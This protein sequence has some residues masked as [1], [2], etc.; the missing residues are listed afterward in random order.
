MNFTIQHA[1]MNYS[2]EEG[3]VG[4]VDFQVENHKEAYEITLYSKK[5]KDWMYSLHFLNASGSEE[6]ISSV[7]EWIEENDDFFDQLVEAAVN[8]LEE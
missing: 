4:K 5:R 7:E 1:E 6:E 2:K 8:T 3:Y